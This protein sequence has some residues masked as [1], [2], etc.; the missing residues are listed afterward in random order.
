MGGYYAGHPYM[1]RLRDKNVLINAVKDALHDP[2]FSGQGFALAQTYDEQTG[3]FGGLAV[4]I[5]DLDVGIITDD[6][7]LVKPD[8]AISQRR[9][10]REANVATPAPD[11]SI[12][13]STG[14]SEPLGAGGNRYDGP[15]TPPPQPEPVTTVA[16]ARYS[17]HLEIDGGADFSATF[18]DL[19][20]EVLQHL[21]KASPDV[22]DITVEV[23]AEKSAGFDA[24]TARVV[25]RTPASSASRPHG[26]RKA[27]ELGAGTRLSAT[28]GPRP[29]DHLGDRSAPLLAHGDRR[30]RG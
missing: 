7:L 6:T 15:A 26:S 22:L 14:A 3:L 20:D 1:S 28:G 27:S 24:S 18:R 9:A 8:L 25:G 10:E 17:G 19:V 16:N 21:Q 12:G 30:S 29:I 4:P 23:N 11:P 2:G 5:E 13:M